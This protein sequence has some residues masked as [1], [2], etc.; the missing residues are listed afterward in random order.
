MSPSTSFLVLIPTFNHPGT[1]EFAIRSAL[2]Q[3][4]TEVHVA[5][6]G[7]G[8]S[9]R[10]RA[11]VGRLTREDRRLR[12]YDFPKS[13]SHGE[14]H[15]DRII[16]ELSPDYVTYLGDDDLLLPHHCEVMLDSLRKADFVHPQPVYIGQD[17]QV[18]SFFRT[19]LRVDLS[20]EWH[21]HFP[22]QNSISL[23]GATHTLEAYLSLNE[24]WTSTPPNRWSDHF[25]WQKFFTTKGLRFT[26]SPLSTTMKFRAR[27]LSEEEQVRQI[28]YFFQRLS[29][30][31]FLAEWDHTVATTVSRENVEAFIERRRLRRE[32]Q[33][34]IKEIEILRGEATLAVSS[35]AT[36][37][38]RNSKL[39]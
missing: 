11:I 24:G 26:T 37:D 19:D 3:T 30:Q 10:T 8:V 14:E 2:Q 31:D 6:V 29:H 34:A 39:S 20:L 25:M 35:A 4:L 13:V 32:L 9:E 18:H 12:F 1:V 16:R 33:E 21:M 23:T 15:R 36:R 5:V 22:W 17:G 27:P 38:A 7:D 28:R